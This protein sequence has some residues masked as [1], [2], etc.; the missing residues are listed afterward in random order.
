MAK[1]QSQLVACNWRLVAISAEGIF[2]IAWYRSYLAELFVVIIMPIYRILTSTICMAA[3]SSKHAVNGS[4]R[5][6]VDVV[7]FAE[8]NK[9][10]S[11]NQTTLYTHTTHTH[12]HTQTTEHTTTHM[13][14]VPV[15]CVLPYL[16]FHSL[17]H[18]Q[19]AC[20][21]AQQS[22][23]ESNTTG[24][25]ATVSH[26]DQEE[27]TTQQKQQENIHKHINRRHTIHRITQPPPHPPHSIT[28]HLHHPTTVHP[29]STAT[30]QSTSHSPM[31]PPSNRPP[32]TDSHTTQHAC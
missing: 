32:P 15:R 23:T 19:S 22:A 6:A 30:A 8:R 27:L 14:T 7:Q 2:Y 31:T 12:T 3:R 1:L 21:V 25:A 10:R 4:C 17:P 28:S 26:H 29:S 16:A 20:S 5:P 18:S 9:N 24:L 11:V 13:Q